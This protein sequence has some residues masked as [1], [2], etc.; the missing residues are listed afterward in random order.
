MSDD[1]ARET[2]VSN[3]TGDVITDPRFIKY[4]MGSRQ[5]FWHKNCVALVLS[6][7]F[8]EP[9]ESTSI[10]LVMTAIFRLIRLF[11]FSDKSDALA[12]RFN[13]ET[14]IEIE[15]I[16]DFI[17]LHYKQTQR[18]DSDFWNFYRTMDI[19]ETL[20]YRMQI[21]KENGYVWPDDVALFR[22]DSWVQ[23]MMGQGLMP[24]GFHNA[25]KLSGTNLQQSLAKIKPSIDNTVQK[26]PTYQQFIDHYCT[27]PHQD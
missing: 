20:A 14:R 4:R 2:L 10:H 22:V 17:I 24:E 16:R 13:Q 7:G 12:D 25:G 6:S 26:L 21:F 23:V 15:T 18:Q 3:L 11:P 9:L 8:I 27:A 1:E 19:P 5:K